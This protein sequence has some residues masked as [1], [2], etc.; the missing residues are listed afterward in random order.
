MNVIE[1]ALELWTNP[2]SIVLSPIAGLGSEIYSAVRMG[3]RG[4]GI[5]LKGSYF[6][7][8]V[9][10]CKVAELEKNQISMFGG[11]E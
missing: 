8:A 2:R 1:R 4:V 9:E 7:Q 10:N 3:R 5:E 11:I 6:K